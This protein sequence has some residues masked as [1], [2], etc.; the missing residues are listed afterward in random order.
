MNVI[1]KHF[2]G[3]AVKNHQ[4]DEEVW[5]SDEDGRHFKIE[6]ET[7]EIKAGFGG[8][9]N[10][11]KADPSKKKGYAPS[12]GSLGRASRGTTGGQ[13]EKIAALKRQTQLAR[14]DY[15]T[16]GG[17]KRGEA[18]RRAVASGRELHK[19]QAEAERMNGV[20][21]IKPNEAGAISGLELQ[22]GVKNIMNGSEAPA[23]INKGAAYVAAKMQGL[24][25]G[26]YFHSYTPKKGYTS[27]DVFSKGKD[28][29]WERIHMDNGEEKFRKKGLSDNEVA[30]L[31]VGN[32][33]GMSEEQMLSRGKAAKEQKAAGKPDKNLYADKVASLQ[34]QYADAK[35]EYDKAKKVYQSNENAEK[36]LDYMNDMENA[37]YTMRSIQNDLSDAKFKQG[38]SPKRQKEEALRDMVRLP[39]RSQHIEKVPEATKILNDLPAGSAI[40]ASSERGVRMD[41]TKNA[42]GTWKMSFQGR[43]SDRGSGQTMTA[44]AM[45]SY[46]LG[47][48]R[49]DTRVMGLNLRKDGSQPTRKFDAGADAVE[50]RKLL[51]DASSYIDRGTQE[52]ATEILESAPVGTYMRMK[53]GSRSYYYKKTDE[54]TWRDANSTG[55]RDYGS[56]E[57]VLE[58]QPNAKWVGKFDIDFGG[59]ELTNG[60]SV[61]E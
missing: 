3:K 22:N 13:E 18:I 59:K 37:E 15:Y 38:L 17:A 11:Q 30:K 60:W 29:T 33:I 34:K 32:A 46:I 8:K 16:S 23:A 28:G 44:N 56:E 45:A 40:S 36:N 57:V 50:F 24:P 47:A 61:T 54:G 2:I 5:R 14:S 41:F 1:D 52:K 21:P 20:K 48:D 27:T 6:T 26:T 58:L 42:D 43:P 12:A 19:A 39:Y 53:Q 55:R 9:L 7:G 31:V 49:T 4:R 10:G 51:P 35:A 25:A